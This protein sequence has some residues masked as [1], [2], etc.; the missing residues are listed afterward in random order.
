VHSD[1][2]GERHKATSNILPTRRLLLRPKIP[3]VHPQ[4]SRHPPLFRRRLTIS[5]KSSVLDFS[6]RI[7]PCSTSWDASA[8]LNSR[9]NGLD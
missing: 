6:I 2:S 1:L 8:A 5:P 4:R 3:H 7:T 9:M